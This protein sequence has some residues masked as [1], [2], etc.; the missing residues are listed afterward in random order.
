MG[1]TPAGKSHVKWDN[2]N[3]AADYL[4]LVQTGGVVVGW[5][6]SGGTP[7]GSL[8]QTSSGGGGISF[9]SS[10]PAACTPGV[11]LPVG[12]SVAPYGIYSCTAVNTWT[13]DS[14]PVNALVPSDF[15]ITFDGR[16]CY[17]AN[18]SWTSGAN[19][20]VTINTTNCPPFTPADTGKAAFGTNGAGG[21]MDCVAASAT[22]PI[23]ILTYI[24]PT[25][26]SVAV[27]TGSASTTAAGSFFWFT[28][29][30]AK[31]SLLDAAFQTFAA[32]LRL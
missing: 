3:G 30:R 5:I 25:Q 11:T 18:V 22:L 31:W 20:T 19:P 23:G 13:R 16:G 24:S 28:D 32:V 6:D 14:S 10:L 1:T 7:R 21:V 4:Q 15:G 9:V 29:D 26:A 17:G 27:T 8:A 2:S 12:L